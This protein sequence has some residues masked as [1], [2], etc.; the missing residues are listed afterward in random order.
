MKRRTT[1]GML[2]VLTGGL[3]AGGPGLAFGSPAGRHGMMK[4]F[5]SATIDDALATAS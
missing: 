5:V 3:L 2:G 1:I 4:R